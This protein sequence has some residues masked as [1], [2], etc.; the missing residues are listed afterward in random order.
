MS[1]KSPDLAEAAGV[2]TTLWEPCPGRIR[3]G[4]R[5]TNFY[6][7]SFRPSV[8][9]RTSFTLSHFIFTTTCGIGITL[10]LILQV[11]TL[12]T[13]AVLWTAQGLTSQHDPRPRDRSGD[14]S[15]TPTF[16]PP[17]AFSFEFPWRDIVESDPTSTHL[18]VNSGT[19][20]VCLHHTCILGSSLLL[21]GTGH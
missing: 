7:A 2:G 8:E 14:H 21:W 12:R 20:C 16:L 1:N 10:I 9:P 13:R 4:E 3:K 19:A 18:T 15:T 5:M 11:R 17:Q 6:R